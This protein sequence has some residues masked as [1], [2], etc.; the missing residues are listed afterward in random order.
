MVE[1]RPC[2]AEVAAAICWF[3]SARTGS[4]VAPL[5]PWAAFG[6]GR[7]GPEHRQVRVADLVSPDG[8]GHGGKDEV[9][10]AEAE[11]D[12]DEVPL[13]LRDGGI[14]G[15]DVFLLLEPLDI[16]TQIGTQRCSS[17]AEI[18]LG[19][20]VG[21]G[22][23][24]SVDPVGNGGRRLGLD[25]RQGTDRRRG[26]VCPDVLGRN[27]R[28]RCSRGGREAGGRA[29]ALRPRLLRPHTSR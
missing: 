4:T 10:H 18:L 20:D 8:E 7:R 21:D 16:G 19:F 9:V 11:E 15:D 24:E 25:P 5:W 23:V 17:V 3:R 1:A 27:G 6:L 28:R 22:L 12:V 2:V 13:C 29:R 14:G 26:G